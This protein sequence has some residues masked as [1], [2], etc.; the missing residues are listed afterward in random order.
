[1]KG[2]ILTAGRSTRMYPATIAVNKSFVPVYDKPM[3]YYP[4]SI[5]MMMGIREITFGINRTDL[6]VCRSLLSD[7][8]RLGLRISYTIEEPRKG[9]AGAF[10]I[11]QEME[12]NEP[13]ALVLGDNVTFGPEIAAEVRDAA[14]VVEER[15]G[16]EIIC[17]YVDDPRDFGVIRQDGEGRLLSLEGRSATDAGNCAIT[18]IF[19][20]EKAAT[21]R[22]R[23]VD[24]PIDGNNQFR[25]VLRDHLRE[26]KLHHRI[27]GPS[28]RWY[29]AGRPDRVLEAAEAVKDYQETYQTYAGCV[30]E[31][32]YDNGWISRQQLLEMAEEMPDTEYGKYLA[33]RC[34]DS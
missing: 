21:S 27:L 8:S 11:G 2:I 33:E 30:E 20:F 7:G 28:T 29:D 12:G 26:G 18:G 13:I 31:I 32:A 10:F 15:G 25:Q 9:T 1:M 19:I 24:G 3:I 16:M 5:L 22:I 23:S 6:D 4:L 14:A 17:S 34:K